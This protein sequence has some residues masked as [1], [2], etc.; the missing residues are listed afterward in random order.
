MCG[1]TTLT[2]T[3]D[4]LQRTFG[5]T[6]P[7]GYRPRF[8]VAPSQ[9]LL[10]LRERKGEKGFAELRW[11]LVPFWA[12]D[13]AI[14]SR[15]INARAESLATKAAFREAFDR[16]RC[17]VVVD[18]FYEWRSGPAGRRPHWIHQKDRRPFTLAAL[19][20]RWRHETEVIES[21]AIVTCP[22]NRLM[23]PIHDRMP[24]IIPVEHR[25]E[26]MDP[27]APHDGLKRLLGPYDGEDLEVYEVSTLVNSPANNTEECV[28]P[29]P[30][31]L[32]LPLF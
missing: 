18:G 28:E 24:V 14:G 16:R 5:Y 13:P 25:N 3:A 8:N 26:W 23:E 10:A 12:T 2:I 4:D 21:C 20:E 6:P 29:V 31:E 17:L 30:G 7:A 19:W 22:A 11:G 1:R 9:D 27:E 15:L 32:M